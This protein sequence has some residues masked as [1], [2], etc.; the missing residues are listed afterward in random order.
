M[1]IKLFLSASLAT[2]GIWLAAAYFHTIDVASYQSHESTPETAQLEEKQPAAKLNKE[3]ELETL[4]L[5]Q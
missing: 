3:S 1:K 2:L 4:S 5:N